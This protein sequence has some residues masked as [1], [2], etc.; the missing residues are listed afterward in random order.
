[1]GDSNLIVRSLTHR[2]QNRRLFDGFDLVATAGGVHVIT[3]PSGVGKSTLLRMVGGIETPDA[4]S[5]RVFGREVTCLRGRGLREYLRHS[6]GFVFQDPGL[7]D[8]WTVRKDLTVARAAA[9]RRPVAEPLSVE[10]SLDQVGLDP[11]VLGRRCVD[12]SGGERQRVAFAR[13][14]V[15]KP[16][17]VLLDEPTAALDADRGATVCDLMRDLADSGAAVVVASHDPAVA[18]SSDTL[19]EIEGPAA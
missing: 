13:I 8:R 7:V 15:R 3:G 1:M 14:L 9:P 5:I 17:L 4:G 18:E 10:S 6:V 11:D 16:P 12:L 2:V 19:T